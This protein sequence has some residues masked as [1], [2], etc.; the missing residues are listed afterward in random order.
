MSSAEVSAA[1][2]DLLAVLA[3]LRLAE[4]AASG[5]ELADSL[6]MRRMVHRSLDHDDLRIVD[7]LDQSG[8]F[9]A[10][11]THP[12]PAVMELT[13]CR[14]SAAR[15]TVRVAAALFPQVTPTGQ[16][17]EPVLSATAV[18]FSE[19][20]IDVDHAA[21]IRLVLASEAARRLDP[22]CGPRPSVSWLTGRGSTGLMS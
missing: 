20:A 17:L 21:V 8:F 12:G 18:A 22:S 15:R 4:S 7:A 5:Q 13:G 3:R 14:K 16:P 2:R 19:S 9:T 10:Q 11:N 1:H 6:K